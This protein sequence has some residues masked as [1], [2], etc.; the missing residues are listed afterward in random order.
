MVVPVDIVNH[1]AC[2]GVP[3]GVNLPQ[4]HVQTSPTRVLQAVVSA[5]VDSKS[6]VELGATEWD[7][8]V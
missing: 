1:F 5:Y 6:R 2:F 3:T 4:M 8:P 7:R